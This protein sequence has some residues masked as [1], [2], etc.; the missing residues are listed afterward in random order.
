MSNLIRNFRNSEEGVTALEYGLIAALAAIL[1]IVA[2]TTVGPA[3]G[4][5]VQ[6]LLGTFS[7]FAALRMLDWW[8]TYAILTLVLIC[9]LARMWKLFFLM[10]AALLIVLKY[11][12]IQ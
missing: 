4:Y 8:A 7:D 5:G 1:V 3:V 12:L 10:L 6:Y 2:M 9:L 11:Q